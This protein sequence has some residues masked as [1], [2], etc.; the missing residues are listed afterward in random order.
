MENNVVTRTKNSPKQDL[1][2]EY[3]KFDIHSDNI[4]VLPA[5]LELE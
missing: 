3:L 4:H 5:K 2:Q 1:G